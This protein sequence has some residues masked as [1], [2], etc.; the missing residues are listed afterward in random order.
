[1]LV[2]ADLQGGPGRYKVVTLEI[3]PAGSIVDVYQKTHLVPYGEYAPFRAELSWLPM[4]SQ[5]PEDAVA[6]HH[7]KVLRVAGGV[8]A[9]VLSFEDDFASLVQRRIDMGGRLLVVGTNT[10]TWGR[11]AASAQHVAMS[12]VNAASNGVWV[13]HAALS[14]I[15]AFVDPQ[16]EVAAETPMWRAT[17]LVHD[18]SF[19]RGVTF[20]ARYGDWAAYVCVALAAAFL[21][22]SP[23]GLART[24]WVPDTVPS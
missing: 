2:G 16:G 9:P 10:S 22:A 6:A 7:G 15:S 23:V 4:L 11:S 24:R 19:A 20:Y 13:V 12:Q 5:I 18:V 17:T 21:L 1:M 14:G 3:S 8:V